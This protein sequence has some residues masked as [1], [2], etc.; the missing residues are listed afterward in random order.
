MA[1]R[2]ASKGRHQG[3]DGDG[4]DQDDEL[5]L[6]QGVKLEETSDGW[7]IRI[8]GSSTD[9]NVQVARKLGD[10]ATPFATA[11]ARVLAGMTKP[12]SLHTKFE[13]LEWGYFRFIE[14][15]AS[16]PTRAEDF[17][18][19]H[20]TRYQQWLSLQT[21]GDKGV[22]PLTRDNKI[23]KS[24]AL[25]HVL[26]QLSRKYPSIDVSNIVP[27][28]PWPDEG[29]GRDPKTDPLKP[30]VFAKL[31][32]H[33]ESELIAL[34]DKV[35][36][37]FPQDA[38]DDHGTKRVRSVHGS[39]E[40]QICSRLIADQGYLPRSFEI[41]E[42]IGHLDLAA[43]VRTRTDPKEVEFCA[44][45]TPK[46]L[47]LVM[48]Y[49]LIYTGF[50]EQPIRDLELKD[51]IST[52]L[53]GHWQTLIKTEKNRA[54]TPIRRVF[55][56]DPNATISVTRVINCMRK[57]TSLLRQTAPPQL[58]DKLLLY[59]PQR[60]ETDRPVASFA[61][62]QYDSRSS[63]TISN[64]AV[65]LSKELGEPYIGSMAIR[66]TVAELLHQATNNDEALVAAGLGHTDPT[67]TNRFYRS[68][69][70]KDSDEWSLAGVMT[71]RTRFLASNGRVDPRNSVARRE[72][73]AATPGF[74]CM[75]N[76]DSPIAGQIKGEPCIAYPFC[77]ACP[78]GQP[79]ENRAYVLAVVAR[80][81]AM[82]FELKTRVG[83]QKAKARFG[84][85]FAALESWREFLSQDGEVLSAAE[86]VKLGAFPPLE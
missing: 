15:E 53:L 17:N 73:S 18:R 81:G 34:L 78:L 63:S 41:E 22:K 14:Q 16:P 40:Y 52:L 31:V 28:N 37:H 39:A 24:G 27:V 54:R 25:K 55:S 46:Q 84:P 83:P 58:R 70:V 60:R 68:R 7:F 82:L 51:I 30:E 69:G 57:W 32:K 86:A 56:D 77:P 29:S 50:N 1:K 72:L 5:V 74:F 47:Y 10:M 79:V 3:G 43:R 4:V 66:A 38:L 85:L 9:W 49:L 80:L 2:G 48:V 67:T 20:V 71:L 65:A 21:S 8:P 61:S 59:L 76:L 13:T 62:L 19:E 35:D 6:P 33:V 64:H 23:Q 75:D 45:P 44:G 42:F 26:M 11:V 36:R 12:T